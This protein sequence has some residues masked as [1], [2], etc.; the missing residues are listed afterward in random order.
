MKINHN[1]HV[2]VNTNRGKVQ[3]YLGM[4]I[5]FTW[6]GRVKI[7]MYNYVERI[8]NELPMKISKSDTDSTPDRNNLFEKGN[9]KIMGK[10][11]NWRIPYFISKRNVCDQESETRYSSNGS[12]VVN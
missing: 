3:N 12:G 4:N 9:I 5:D 6:K 1:K 11:V 2:K 8:N 7:K 10:K